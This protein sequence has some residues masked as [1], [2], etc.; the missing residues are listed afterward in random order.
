MPD[1]GQYRLVPD[2]KSVTLGRVLKRPRVIAIPIIIAA[3]A[4]GL[5]CYLLAGYLTR[6]I[7]RL[8]QATRQ[9]AS[10]DL[11]QRVTPEMGGRRD[12]IV[13]LARDFD[14]M[15]ERLEQLISSI[16]W[17]ARWLLK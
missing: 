4:S 17:L 3:L 5:V 7:R 12:E 13:D 1:G 15:A 8:S 10:G 9:F 16:F 14:V 11:S 2:F 6:P